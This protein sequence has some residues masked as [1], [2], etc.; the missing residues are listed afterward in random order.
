MDFARAHIVLQPD[1]LQYLLSITPRWVL[2]LLFTIRWTASH[3]VLFVLLK[4]YLQLLSSPSPS[5]FPFPPS[6]SR[7]ILPFAPYIHPLLPSSFHCPI[8]SISSSSSPSLPS[9]LFP[10]ALPFSSAPPFKYPVYYI[11]IYDCGTQFY[12][13]L[14]TCVYLAQAASAP[15]S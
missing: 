8:V 11:E 6:L 5:P 10:S 1:L 12:E 3:K 14:P 2:I 13:S 15:N 7:F 9:S 4:Y